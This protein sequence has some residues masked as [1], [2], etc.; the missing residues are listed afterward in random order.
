MPRHW[1]AGFEISSAVGQ[2]EAVR[3][4][5]GIGILH[6]FAARNDPT[7]QRVLPEKTIVRSYWMVIHE[8]L[9]ELARVRTV[10]DFISAEVASQ[11]A[12]FLDLTERT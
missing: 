8:S 6:D 1:E 10:T 4:G 12:A 11:R 5:A 2:A 7:L 9:R 3:A